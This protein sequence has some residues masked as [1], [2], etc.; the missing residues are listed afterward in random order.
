MNVKLTDYN[1]TD[2]KLTD[3]L[4]SEKLPTAHNASISDK[5]IDIARQNKLTGSIIRG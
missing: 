2:I 4:I 3:L 5:L 1:L